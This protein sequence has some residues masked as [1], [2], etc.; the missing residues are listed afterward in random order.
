MQPTTIPTLWNTTSLTCNCYPPPAVSVNIPL[1]PINLI[2]LRW[3]ITVPESFQYLNNDLWI[4]ASTGVVITGSYNAD[5]NIVWS[6][7]LN[8]T[9]DLF[10]YLVPT[11]ATV[12]ANSTGN[13]STLIN[14]EYHGQYVSM[15]ANAKYPWT[16]ERGEWFGFSVNFFDYL[17][18]LY[19]PVCT[20][21][22]AT[23]QFSI[24]MFPPDHYC[25]TSEFLS[26]LY[27]LL[28]I[29]ETKTDFTLL[30][31]PWNHGPLPGL[32]FSNCAVAGDRSKTAFTFTYEI[33]PVCKGELGWK[34]EGWE[35][36]VFKWKS[37]A[38]RVGGK[39]VDNNE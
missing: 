8:G 24:F 5:Q 19:Y 20:T 17:T 27:H 39:K 33:A 21:E 7:T 32:V 30:G 26:L 23:V 35:R 12:R 11:D 22:T 15:F 6:Y 37:Q 9:T 31:Q 28:I 38:N 16:C 4:N 34:D 36:R 14:F 18:F 13:V 3:R 1:A 2:S 25:F 29:F 10:G